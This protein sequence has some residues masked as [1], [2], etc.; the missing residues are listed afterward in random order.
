MTEGTGNGS[1]SVDVRIRGRDGRLYPASPLTPEERRRARML[2]H[3]LVHRDRLSIRFA[4]QV[5][6]EQYGLRRSVG[7]IARDLAGWVCDLCDD[8]A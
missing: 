4:Q 1:V 5:M 3:N 7:A 2:A 6:A 8:D